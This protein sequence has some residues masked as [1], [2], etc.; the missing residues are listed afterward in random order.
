MTEKQACTLCG[1]NEDQ[2]PL[3]QVRFEGRDAALCPGCLPAI[4]HGLPA[5]EARARFSAAYA[6]GG[7]A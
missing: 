6:K 7:K 3:I 1:T 2:R 5:E 4:I